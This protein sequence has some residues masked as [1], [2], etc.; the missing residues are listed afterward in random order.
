MRDVP[1]WINWRLEERPGE[2]KPA[3]VPFSVVGQHRITPHDPTAWLSYE[4]AIALD[5][6]HIG[7][8]LTAIDPYFCIDLDHAW[9]GSEWSAMSSD[10]LA[11]FPGAYVEVSYS[12]DGLHVIGQGNKTPG[13]MTRGPGVEF[14]TE[15]R[16]IAITA[17]GAYGDADAYNHTAGLAAFAPMYLKPEL[18]NVPGSVTEW[19][20]EAVEG[21]YGPNLTDDDLIKKMLNATPSTAVAFET[22]AHVK[23]IWNNNAVVLAGFYPPDTPDK[24]YG[25]SEVDGALAGHLAFWTGKDCARIERLMR[26]SKLVRDK[27]NR[28]GDSYM[29]R[30]IVGAVAKC[31]KVYT[32]P[33]PRTAIPEGADITLRT[34]HQFFDAVKQHEVFAGCVYIMGAHKVFDPHSPTLL[35]PEQ[36]NHGRFAGYDYEMADGSG[37]KPTRKPFE[38]FTQS[39]ITKF[40]KAN[41]ICFR[42]ELATSQIVVEGGYSLV[43]TYVAPNVPMIAGDA[44]PFLHHMALLFPDPNDCAIIMSYLA[45]I[46]Q[47]PG[48]K[49]R[50]CPLIQGVEGNG[51]GVVG[52]VAEQMVGENYTHKPLAKEFGESGVKFTGWL[53]RKLL[54]IIE[55]IHAGERREFLDAIKPLITDDRVEIQAKGADQI[56]GENRA[57]FI[58]T[59]NHKDALMVTAD[60]RRYA[61]FFTGQQSAADCVRDGMGGDYMP[62]LWK[63]LKGGGY[64]VVAHYLQTLAI[65]DALNPATTL[66]RA[67][68]TSSTD[69]AIVESRGLVEQEIIQAC[70]DGRQGFQ[71]GWVSSV[72]L[73]RLLHDIRRT[74]PP[75]KR[76]VVLAGLGYIPHPAF[77][78]GQCNQKIIQEDHKRPTLYVLADSPAASLTEGVD[79]F[80]AY[81]N[82]QGYIDAPAAPLRVLTG[83]Q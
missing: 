78:A 56:T 83:S 1:Q 58:L 37:A 33:P 18:P 38:A 19:T 31:G 74:I 25:Q 21:A 62:N 79:A 55:E 61:V 41:A 76:G 75:R 54:I 45:A 48:V 59:S 13:Y 39:R 30:T 12:G 22:K 7:F 72:Q 6:E 71:G 81:M 16:F 34:G 51:K 3:K 28:K 63:W 68:R 36:F 64:A 15:A 67:P 73:T 9:N 26:R 50:W 20:T 43:N 29:V 70:I 4:Q 24:P 52:S 60:S 53:Q 5:P 27:W 11:R 77:R 35:K 17:T 2:P 80:A 44:S 57:N 23:D 46:K 10:I 47:Y 40:P 8:V 42:P 49:F 69:N 82:A 65:P 14:Y 32:G 66:H